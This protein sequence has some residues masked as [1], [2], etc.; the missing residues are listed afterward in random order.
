MFENRMAV[1]WFLCSS[2]LLCFLCTKAQ[3]PDLKDWHLVKQKNG[4]E[5]YTAPGGHDGLKLI[6]VSA[7]MTGSIERVKQIFSDIPSQQEWVYGTRKA[8]LVKKQ[9][10]NTLLYYNETGLPW[11]ASNRDVV[12][13]MVLETEPGLK[14]LVV[15]QEA[16]PGSVPANKG[17]VRVQ[18]LSGLWR[19]TETGNNKLKA[20]YSLNIDPGGSLP[21]FVVNMFIAKGPY[22]T[23]LRLQQLM[24]R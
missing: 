6:K 23:F 24:R 21:A 2:L 1:Q 9:D 3:V 19:F 18:H 14:S 16:E 20:T 5:V 7:E 15:R 12:I 4:I 11:P 10:E 22:E 13:Q 17:L 8:Y